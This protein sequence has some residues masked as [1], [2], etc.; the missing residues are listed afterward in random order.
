MK[1]NGVDCRVAGDLRGRK[2]RAAAVALL[3]LLITYYSYSVASVPNPA[4][5]LLSA[6]VFLVTSSFAALLW[7]MPARLA[8]SLA[9]GVLELKMLA[10]ARRVRLENVTAVE[11]VDY[12]L[13]RR[14]GSAA[15]PGYYVGRFQSNLGK[16]TAYA[17]GPA[18]KGLLL[19]LRSGELILLTPQD[20]QRLLKAVKNRLPRVKNGEKK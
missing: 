15:L 5:W 2:T 18:G 19:A 3:A 16:L 13:G 20:R 12:A 8:Y 11:E 6:L 17:G 1:N 4:R 9:D 7:L 10:G 14:N